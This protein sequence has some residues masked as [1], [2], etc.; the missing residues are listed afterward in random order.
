MEMLKKLLFRIYSFIKYLF[1]KAFSKNLF[2]TYVNKWFAIDGDKNLLSTY[3]LNEDSIVFE[4]WWYTWVFSNEIIKKYN[5]N[6]YVFEPIKE[7]YEVLKQKF[8]NN[9]KV[10]IFHCWL[11]NKTYSD[12]MYKNNDGSSFYKK[13]WEVETIEFVDIY[14]F[15]T[16][17]KLNDKKIDL[18]SINIEGGGIWFIK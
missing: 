12:K 9:K 5:C 10:K 15:I 7:Y 13:S 4:V 16:E 17:N 14:D 6:L 8:W 3:E 18:I 1:Y 11:T 2:K